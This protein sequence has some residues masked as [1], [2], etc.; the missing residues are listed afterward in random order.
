MELIQLM[1]LLFACVIIAQI[2]MRDD[3]NSSSYSNS[4]YSNVKML[5]NKSAAV[6]S[7]K[8]IELEELRKFNENELYQETI[9]KNS[10]Y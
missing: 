5:K 3:K 2:I 9:R 4:S 7:E 6:R 10:I 8:S 1:L